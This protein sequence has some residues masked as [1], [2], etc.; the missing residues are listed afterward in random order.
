MSTVCFA[1]WILDLKVMTDEI[2]KHFKCAELVKM[3]ATTEQLNFFV[4]ILTKNDFNGKQIH[5]LL[6]FAWGEENVIKLRRVQTLVRDF[7]TGERC[8]FTRKEDSGRPLEVRT[9]SNVSRVK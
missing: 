8:D 5:E 1:E 9:D 6:S 2:P 3:K 4:A 7:Q